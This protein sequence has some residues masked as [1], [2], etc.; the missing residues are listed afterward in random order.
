MQA[1]VKL[2]FYIT[3]QYTF[4]DHKSKVRTTKKIPPLY[5]LMEDNETLCTL[6]SQ[7]SQSTNIMVYES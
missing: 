4:T 1:Q 3:L 2:T 5:K 7:S 6:S